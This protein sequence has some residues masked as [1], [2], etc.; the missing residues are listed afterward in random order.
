[1]TTNTSRTVTALFGMVLPALVA[2]AG[3]TEERLPRDEAIGICVRAKERMAECRTAFVDHFMARA[4]ADLPPEKRARMREGI[5]RQIEREG[6]GPVEPRRQACG[7]VVDGG[8]F[9]RNSEADAFGR[10]LA[11]PDC[12]AV[13]ACF[14]PLL[15]RGGERR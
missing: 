15:P 11:E 14:D 13:V 3:G 6:T 5:R 4:P 1:M 12:A 10:C 9:V 8:S 7:E 2:S